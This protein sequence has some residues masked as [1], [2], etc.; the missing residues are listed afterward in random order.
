VG[1]EGGGDAGGLL[2]LGRG[3]FWSER[4]ELPLVEEVPPESGGRREMI[5][6]LPIEMMIHVDVGVFFCK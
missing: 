2:R 5:M 4:V 3:V 1:R 6:S